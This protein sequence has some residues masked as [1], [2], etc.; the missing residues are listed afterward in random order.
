MVP[1]TAGPATLSALVRFEASSETLAVEVDA[2]SVASTPGAVR[3][4]GEVKDEVWQ[5]VPPVDAF[6]Q[7]V[8]AFESR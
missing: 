2:V 4:S 5:T 6:V 3:V 7:R 8:A 1:A